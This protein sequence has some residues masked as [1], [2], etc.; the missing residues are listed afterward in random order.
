MRPSPRFP[1]PLL[2]AALMLILLPAPSAFGAIQE[3]ASFGLSVA[4]YAQR[5]QDLANN[6]DGGIAI[7]RG[8]DPLAEDFFRFRQRNDFMYLT[9][10][11]QPGAV[12]LL[13]PP[14]PDGEGDTDT[15]AR[16]IVF[17]PPRNR[18]AEHGAVLKL[19]PAKPRK[20]PSDS[21]KRCRST[22]SRR[23]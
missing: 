20:P 8:A 19:A 17:L 16:S 11:D 5:R 15:E 9:G 10:I 6:L 14:A 7:I 2:S 4:E 22:T 21:T 18:F 1:R 12:L 3:P 23:S 13:L